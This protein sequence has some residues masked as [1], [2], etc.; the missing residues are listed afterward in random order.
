[1][2]QRFVIEAEFLVPHYRRIEIW[3]KDE[4][5]AICAVARLESSNPAFW[6]N[7]KEDFETSRPTTY[8]NVTRRKITSSV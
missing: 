4:A 6:R 7:Q 2:R 5:H 3:A 8:A 1:M